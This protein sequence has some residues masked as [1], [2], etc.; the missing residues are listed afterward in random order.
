MLLKQQRKHKFL[1]WLVRRVED[2]ESLSLIAD[3]PCRVY[4]EGNFDIFALC[5]FYEATPP[6]K[7]FLCRPC[8]KALLVDERRVQQPVLSLKRLDQALGRSL[9][10]VGI[11]RLRVAGDKGKE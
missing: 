8:W 6:D 4:A 11:A 3:R 7:E 10:R 2:N 1:I 5:V 9:G